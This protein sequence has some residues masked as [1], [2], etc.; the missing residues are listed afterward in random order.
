MIIL[1]AMVSCKLLLVIEKKYIYS[2]WNI[3]L[4][5]LTVKETLNEILLYTIA[6]AVITKFIA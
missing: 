6:G 5:W 2:L 1:S 4:K 3:D